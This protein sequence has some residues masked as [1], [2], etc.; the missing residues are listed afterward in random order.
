M[1]AIAKSLAG[2]DILV[3][4]T[5]APADD[6][7]TL[8][9]LLTIQ[10]ESQPSGSFLHASGGAH[11]SYSYAQA[12]EAVSRLSAFLRTLK[13]PHGSVA[14]LLMPNQPSSVIALMA[15]L[16][17][18]HVPMLLPA[19]ERFAEL[20]ALALQAQCAVIITDDCADRALPDL[21]VRLAAACEDVRFVMSFGA[22]APNGVLSLA[23]AMRHAPAFSSAPASADM[24]LTA[25]TNQQPARLSIHALIAT[26]TEHAAE[27]SLQASLR[28]VCPLRNHTMQTLCC[29]AI[30]ALLSGAELQL[31]DAP[32]S[33]ALTSAF[34]SAR[35]VH[36]IWP[37]PLEDM[38]DDIPVNALRSVTLVHKTPWERHRHHKMNRT[39]PAPCVDAWL[40]PDRLI[41]FAARPPHSGPT[42]PAIT[43]S[44][45]QTPD[46]Q[47]LALRIHANGQLFAA[48]TSVQTFSPHSDGW[49]DLGCKAFRDQDGTIVALEISPIRPKP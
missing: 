47:A 34:L 18:G 13:L 35:P 29:G 31:L 14:G 24:I 42:L 17:A 40:F 10:A 6:A 46:G 4:G 19:H 9:D 12:H 26:A 20:S 41:A 49:I 22:T 45:D 39:M 8:G 21:A 32:D 15:C 3:G 11:P 1:T 33:S 37:G 5:A 25:G 16:E 27:S 2:D 48:G 43:A 38:L 44:T 7:F 30:S 36:L 28:I 23:Q